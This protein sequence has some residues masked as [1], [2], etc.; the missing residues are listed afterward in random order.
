M[1]T[2]FTTIFFP[3]FPMHDKELLQKWIDFTDRGAYWKPS[4]W[5]SICS[6]HFA[7]NDFREYLSRKCLKKNAVP[8]IVTKN[9]ISYETYHISEHNS[10]T[11]S[12]CGDDDL[13]DEH[14]ATEMTLVPSSANTRTI[15]CRLCGDLIEELPNT[16]STHPHHIDNQETGEMIRKCLPSINIPRHGVGDQSNLIC[17]IC[18]SHL[19][20]FSEFV[21]KVL[22]FQR[23]CVSDNIAFTA[24]DV[25]PFEIR[26]NSNSTS[27]NV[28]FIKQEP[29][30]V[31][32]E[33]LDISNKKPQELPPKPSTTT[34]PIS[35]SNDQRINIVEQSLIEWPR[36]VANTFCQQCERIFINSA[37][38]KAHTCTGSQTPSIDQPTNATNNN[39]EIMEVITLNNPISF[40][41][42]AEDEYAS[43]EQMAVCK[44]EIVVDVERRERVDIE[45]AYAKRS[46]PATA[47]NTYKLK[48][49]I[50]LNDDSD[51]NGD[52]ATETSM[53]IDDNAQ[54]TMP[55]PICRFIC[56]SC[57]QEFT[58]NHL[59]VEHT[60]KMHSLD[61]RICTLCSAEFKSTYEYLL[62]KNK[63][64][65]S[66]YRCQRCKRK[67][68]T[69]SA[70]KI[71][72]CAI[73][74]SD[75]CCS[76]RQCGQYMSNRNRMKKP[77]DQCTQKK[78]TKTIYNCDRCQRSFRKQINYVRCTIRTIRGHFFI[79]V[80][81]FCLQKRH[82][83]GQ[84]GE[85]SL[86]TFST[87]EPKMDT[88]HVIPIALIADAEPLPA[89]ENSVVETQPNVPL[90]TASNNNSNKMKS[91]TGKYVCELCSK[92]FQAYSNLKQH[93]T[94]HEN[95]KRFVCVL[96]P[97][98]FKRI[99]GLNQ[100][101]RG[102][103]YQI[104]PFSC[105][106]CNYTY[107][108]KGDMLRC[109]HSSLKRDAT[110]N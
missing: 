69:R 42:L 18:I 35:M 95:E 17:W 28:L 23:N 58:T 27:N 71:H 60:H 86:K 8:S 44:K 62:H 97:K 90:T 76:R 107:A 77:L 91:S 74:S 38:L 25:L 110:H 5:S 102:F 14:K 31:K 52:I 88:L 59:L 67:F 4:R 21:D 51:S 99:S 2:I 15:G 41:D 103:H 84:C 54:A 87:V 30:N 98:K 34:K 19:Q 106:T 92:P 85:K 89:E 66:G 13:S 82:M 46:S 65:T 101:V 20:K 56:T 10:T 16:P 29:I 7:N 1:L 24:T 57:G 9:N 72:T 73:D 100:H 80:I 33:I 6:R 48:Q 40:I 37:E 49:E 108:L 3:R 104:K 11:N 26:S 53:P 22:T 79:Y 61:A 39:C 45:H 63:V 93:K 81:S 105:P 70:L 36:P 12:H 43:V 78:T 96:C 50:D 32:Q 64:H 75:Y 68:G 55:M 94:T 47:S 83:D 109:R